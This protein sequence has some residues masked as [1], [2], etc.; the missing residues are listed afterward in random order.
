MVDDRGVCE[1]EGALDGLSKNPKTRATAAGFKA[2]WAHIPADGPRGLSDSVYH[3]VDKKNEIYEFVKGDHRLLCFQA[4]GKVVVCSHIFMKKG[5]KTPD[6]EKAK[7]IR[8]RKDYLEALVQGKV[9]YE[10]KGN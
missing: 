3:R 2:W 7:A 4:D 6:D 10:K 5:R 9:V 8:L 1:V